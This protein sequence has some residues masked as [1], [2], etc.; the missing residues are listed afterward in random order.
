[1]NVAA[2]HSDGVAERFHGAGIAGTLRLPVDQR[3][4]RRVGTVLRPVGGIGAE[5]DEVV[6][7]SHDLINV[8]H[9]RKRQAGSKAADDTGHLIKFS[10]VQ[11]G[12]VDRS[13]CIVPGRVTVAHL[14]LYRGAGRIHKSDVLGEDVVDLG[15]RAGIQRGK[16]P[17]CGAGGV[18]VIQH[19]VN[20]VVVGA[21]RI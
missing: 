7:R 16:I 8:A 2:F 6:P 14:R 19:K 18:E 15:Q 20:T 13:R 9:G 11:L 4:P 1:M 12:A 21:D 17:L 5:L 3:T 10:L